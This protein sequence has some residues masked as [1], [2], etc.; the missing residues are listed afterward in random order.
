MKEKWNNHL[1]A[2]Q[3]ARELLKKHGRDLDK[4]ADDLVA[5][6]KTMNPKSRLLEA[7]GEVGLR[8]EGLHYLT[9]TLKG[10]STCPTF[11]SWN[12]AAPHADAP[13]RVYHPAVRRA[14]QYPADRLPDRTDRNLPEGGMLAVA[15]PGRLVQHSSE[16]ELW[17]R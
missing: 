16:S 10:I 4:A 1:K 13:S 9:C 8:R 3:V 2:G 14:R 17:T 5:R 15:L 6:L 7:L 12:S 11:M